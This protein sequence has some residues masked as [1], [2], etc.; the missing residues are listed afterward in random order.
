M[1]G[2]KM[3]AAF[4]TKYGNAEV[5]EVKET[6]KP[7][8][9][10]GEVLIKIM[11]AGITTADSMMRQGTPRYAR[12]F[13]GLR[14]PK[15]AIVG[16]GFAGIV[17]AKGKGVDEFEIGDEV[18]GE[19]GLVFSSNAEFV[20]IPTDG[21]ILHKPD[22][23]TFEEAAPMCDGVLT[24]LNFLQELAKVQKGQKVLINGASGSLGVAAIQIA[25]HF[26]AHVTGVCS[27]KNVELVKSLGAD[28]VID[29][30][31]KD[32]TLSSNTYDVIYD[33]IGA[34]S[35]SKSKKVLTE[36]GLYLSPV[37]NMALLFRMLVTSLFGKKK[38][39][40]QATGLRAAPELK[41]LL[42]DFLPVMKSKAVKVFIDKKYPL[43]DIVAA[44]SYIDTGRKRG[45]IILLVNK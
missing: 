28:E 38:A 45:N 24:S 16:T 39:I 22:F 19:T 6:N 33:T 27:T 36:K 23:L 41:K 26:G 9:K 40:F 43:E 10:D 14:R 11:V 30:K 18:F 44:H 5:L 8:P 29:Y 1:K 12:L 32:F 17:E 13:L 25:K 21:I 20:C 15:Q 2:E 37:L 4:C 31:V 7:Q 34:S 42:T 35:F 3:K